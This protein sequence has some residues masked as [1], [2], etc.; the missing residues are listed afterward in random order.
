MGMLLRTSAVYAVA[1]AAPVKIVQARPMG[2]LLRT[3]VVYAVATAAPV[4]LIRGLRKLVS[5]Q[6]STSDLGTTYTVR[7][8]QGSTCQN[9][10]VFQILTAKSQLSRRFALLV[11]IVL[12]F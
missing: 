12:G 7:V 4:E 3:T 2:T 10:T 8:P 5:A 9:V 11:V 1:T 6:N